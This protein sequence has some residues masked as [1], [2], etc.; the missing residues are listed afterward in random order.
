LTLSLNNSLLQDTD[1]SCHHKNKVFSL[2]YIHSYRYFAVSSFIKLKCYQE[3]R[4]D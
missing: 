2:L 3:R 1:L 4:R